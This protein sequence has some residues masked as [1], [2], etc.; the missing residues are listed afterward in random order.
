M[1]QGVRRS[2][3]QA[4][5]CYEY[6]TDENRIPGLD[7]T[8]MTKSL[9]IKALGALLIALLAAFLIFMLPAFSEPEDAAIGIAVGE[10]APIDIAMRD[11]A[12]D[13]TSLAAIAGSKGTVLVMTR[14]VDWCPFCA[15]QV[16]D[17]AAIAGEL[18]KRGFTLASLSYDEPSI[19]AA[20]KADHAIPHPMLSDVDWQFVRATGLR[21]PQYEEGHMAYG[22][23]YAT[24]LV[25]SPE[26][27]VLNRLVSTDYRQRPSNETVLAMVEKA[28]G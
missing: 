13:P 22:V 26:G 9:A 24:V 8:S 5:C 18:A 23:P 25:L 14:S 4:A 6:S 15:A 11:P 7:L 2:C 19:L 16:K 1:R 12:G 3:N 17:H 20:F 21:D 27:T 10:Q 28:A